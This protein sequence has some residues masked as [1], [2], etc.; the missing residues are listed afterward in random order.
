MGSKSCLRCIFCISGLL[1]TLPSM[2]PKQGVTVLPNLH[3]EDL[4]SPWRRVCRE[5]G[6]ISPKEVLHL[7]H[8]LREV[9]EAERKGEDTRTPRNGWGGERERETNWAMVS[10]EASSWEEARADGGEGTLEGSI[11]EETV[12]ASSGARRGREV[13]VLDSLGVS[14]APDIS[15]TFRSHSIT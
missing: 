14:K 8:C 4:P 3:L 13:R 6:S 2:F 9:E 5:V 10:C 15:K 11:S 12:Q 7:Y 1:L